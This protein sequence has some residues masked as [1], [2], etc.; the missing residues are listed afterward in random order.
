MFG[1]VIFITT[2]FLLINSLIKYNYNVTIEN[3]TSESVSFKMSIGEGLVI[4]TV[5]YKDELLSSVTLNIYGG[6][7]KF[8]ITVNDS[9]INNKHVFVL[10]NQSGI[11]Y[12]SKRNNS[13]ICFDFENN[14]GSYIYSPPLPAIIADEPTE[15]E[16]IIIKQESGVPPRKSDDQ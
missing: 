14:Y 11:V 8:T 10:K 5:L 6:I 16:P 15:E 3:T 13:E 1:L 12:V 2:V 4:D 7:K 9:I